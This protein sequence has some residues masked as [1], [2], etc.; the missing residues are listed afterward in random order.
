MSEQIKFTPEP[1]NF[2]EDEG[3]LMSDLANIGELKR[4]Y[5]NLCERMRRVNDFIAYVQNGLPPNKKVITY[6][7]KMATE[8]LTRDET[9]KY[10]GQSTLYGATGLLPFLGDGIE[11]RAGSDEE[12]IVTN[13]ELG[14][15]VPV[16]VIASI[17]DE[18]ERLLDHDEDYDV[19]VDYEK[20]VFERFDEYS[21]KLRVKLQLGEKSIFADSL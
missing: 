13:S 21:P 20:D 11:F 1:D 2:L 17:I 4:E 12:L 18:H 7:D 16:G 14:T 6:T 3:Q 15:A 5:A 10:T 9:G 8:I 19:D